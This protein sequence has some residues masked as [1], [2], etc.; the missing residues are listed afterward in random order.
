MHNAS[1]WT[2]Y[3]S[4]NAK[5]CWSTRYGLLNLYLSV[6]VLNSSNKCA[7]ESTCFLEFF[8]ITG[9][10]YNAWKDTKGSRQL[11]VCFFTDWKQFASRKHSTF[12][13]QI[14]LFH[15]LQSI[16]L[17]LLEDFWPISGPCPVISRVSSLFPN[18]PFFLPFINIQEKYVS[19]CYSRH[20][21]LA[22][23]LLLEG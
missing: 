2:I 4:R 12:S 5:L 16:I 15:S 10:R 21:N 8:K 13:S 19:I 20:S 17:L 9:K 14:Y 11:C 1:T 7:Q 22:M 6:I 23:F 18:F 3:C